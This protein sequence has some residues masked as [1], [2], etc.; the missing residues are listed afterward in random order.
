MVIGLFSVGLFWSILLY[1]GYKNKQILRQS[2]FRS[3][4]AERKN[5]L[6]RYLKECCK[7]ANPFSKQN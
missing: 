2:K 3:S 6:K 4:L 7:N 1:H 5:N